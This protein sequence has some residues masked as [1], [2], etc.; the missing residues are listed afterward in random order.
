VKDGWEPL[1]KFLDMPIPSK[2]FPHR[3]KKG[4]ITEELVKTHPVFKRVKI[5]AAISFGCVAI[6]LSYLCFKLV[7]NYFPKC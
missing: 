5:E 2:P 3:N 7:K 4:E 6:S 1:C